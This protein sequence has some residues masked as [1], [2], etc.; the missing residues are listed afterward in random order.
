MAKTLLMVHG[1][2]CGGEVWD[3]MR[4][5]FE[6]AGWTC[7]AP[8]LFADL[9]TKTTPPADL[10]KLRL[11]DYVEAMAARADD[12]TQRDGQRIDR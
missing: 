10:A 4:R 11:Q 7:D 6:A 3:R 12:L 1:V 8:T 9:R 2:G 5:G